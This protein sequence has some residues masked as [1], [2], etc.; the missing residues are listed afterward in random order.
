VDLGA[1]RSQDLLD[2]ADPVGEA[3][4]G[5]LQVLEALLG[6]GTHR[7]PAIPSGV[8]ELLGAPLGLGQPSLCGGD[9][10]FGI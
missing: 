5:H 8:F 1:H 3:A 2:V 6:F 4:F 7:V 9:F 10:L